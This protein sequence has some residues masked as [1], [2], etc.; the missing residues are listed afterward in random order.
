MRAFVTGGTGFIG[1]HV[2]KQLRAR[3]DEVV[4]LVRSPDKGGALKDIGC[5]LVAGDL[6]ASDAIRAG[7][8]GCDAVF[9]LGAVYE[10]GIPKSQ[11]PAMLDANVGGTERVLDAASDAGVPRIVYVSSCVVFGNTRGEIVDENYRRSG[12]YTSYY[13]ETKFLAHEIAEDRIANG[14]PIIIV[15]P[16]GVYGPND[17][18]E[19]GNLIEQTA[20]GKLPA[21][22]F[23]D[24]GTMLCHV[25][26]I[27][28]GILLAFDKG[29]VGEAY[30]LSADQTT[31][32]EL[33]DTIA[34]IAGRKPPRFTMPTAVL[35]VSAPLGPVI[36]PLLG[37]PKNLGEL[38]KSS[39][40]VT[41]WAT[42]AKSRRELGFSPR[43]LDEG[44]RETVASIG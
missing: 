36:G 15:Q 7:M 39:D 28:A 38:I 17:H 43:P 4:A 33:I 5:E 22:V 11:R 44:L 26:D 37:F 35:K 23:P 41:F 25:E 2:V 10:V 13:E 8:E 24:T 32:G 30:I 21:K 1:G 14:A 29:Q 16:G 40:G 31:L 20:T 34:G 18:S 27:A 3:G 19:F 6:S 12:D 9:H 42:D